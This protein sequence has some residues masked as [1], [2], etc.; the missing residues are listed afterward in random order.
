MHHE[1]VNDKGKDVP[2]PN[3]SP[4][5]CIASWRQS[6][7]RSSWIGGCVGLGLRLDAKFQ[8]SLAS[9]NDNVDHI[10]FG[11]TGRKRT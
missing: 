2:V 1:K 11:A 3:T 9:R 5:R 10:H 6:F 8:N 4:Q 7:T